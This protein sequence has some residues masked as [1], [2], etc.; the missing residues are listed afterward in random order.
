MALDAV[1]WHYEQNIH[2]QSQQP[3][4]LLGDWRLV[5]QLTVIMSGA[6]KELRSAVTVTKSIVQ[7]TD[8]ISAKMNH[9]TS[10]LL[11]SADLLSFIHQAIVEEKKKK[12]ALRKE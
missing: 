6:D 4:S 10:H 2:S 11:V 12:I 1:L 3:A 9:S 8:W 7:A 5:V